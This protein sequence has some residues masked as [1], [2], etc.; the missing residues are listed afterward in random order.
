MLQN[1]HKRTYMNKIENRPLSPRQEYI[2]QSAASD[3]RVNVEAL[4]DTLSV[5]PQTIRR[6]LGALCDAG[7]LARVHGG[8]VSA[9]AR[10][11]LGYAERQ[12][13][14]T[15][16]KQAIG[17][18]AAALVPENAT[19]FLNIGTTTE[20]AAMALRRH[21]DLTVVSNNLNIALTLA[22]APG[23][24]VVVTGGSLR[25]ADRGI[26]GAMTTDAIRRF[27]PDVAIIGVSGIDPDGTLLDFDMQEVEA[28]QAI[29]DTARRVILVADRTKFSRHAPVRI[30]EI[31]SVSTLVT[32]QP[33]GHGITA[34]CA[35]AGVEVIVAEVDGDG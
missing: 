9:L 7:L 14:A 23:V 32:D 18:A 17:R 8:A 24:D 25:K 12:A 3:G 34:L 20:C 26:T 21:Q 22:D 2:L 16:A 19:V 28:S 33:P 29:M 13:V 31:T 6:D 10:H 5:T 30:G 27:R 11:N 1:E 35:E 4:A 15:I